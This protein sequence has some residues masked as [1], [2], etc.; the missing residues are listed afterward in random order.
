MES[1]LYKFVSDRR[2][3]L[4]DC[5]LGED[6]V[7]ST[8]LIAFYITLYCGLHVVQANESLDEE[9]GLNFFVQMCLL[10]PPTLAYKPVNVSHFVE[11]LLQ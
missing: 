11:H 7:I 10:S 5:L 2:C 9:G 3:R 1:V 8:L 6:M 4:G